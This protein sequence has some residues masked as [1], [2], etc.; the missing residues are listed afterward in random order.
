M[1]VTLT[2]GTPVEIERRRRFK[3]LIWAYAYE[4]KAHS[5]VP[6]HLFD[7]EALRINTRID[8][9]KPEHDFWWRAWFKPFTAMWIHNH[10]DLDKLEKVYEKHYAT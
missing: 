2:W 5:I 1:V 10:P 6:D 4:F 7:T 3:L 9:G 8:T